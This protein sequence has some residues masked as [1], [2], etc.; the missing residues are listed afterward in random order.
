ME[1]ARRLE[2]LE[3]ILLDSQVEQAE[4]IVRL[5]GELQRRIVMFRPRWKGR[6]VLRSVLHRVLWEHPDASERRAAYFA[7]EELDRS[8]E[9]GLRRLIGLRNEG[10]RLLGYRTF[11]DLRVGFLGLSPAR[12]AELVD[13][14]CVPVRRRARLMRDRFAQG[15]PNAS[16]LP[17]DLQFALQDRVRLPARAFPRRGMVPRVIAAVRR[18]G[19]PPER[20]RFRVVFHDLPAGGLTLAP[21]PPRDVRVVVH[22]AGGW[23]SHM[24]LFHEVGHAVH[25]RSIRAPRHLLRWS[26]NVPGLGALHEGLAGLF[27]E[28]PSS[29]EWLSAQAGIPQALAR[30]YALASR[31][32][33]AFNAASHSVWLT[34]ELELYRHPERDPASASQRFERRLFGYDE[35]PSR[36]FVDSFYVDTPLYSPNYLLS[37]LFSA[38]LRQAL[39]DRLGGPFWP[40]TRFGPWL[41]REWFAGGSTFDWL[42]RLRET[43]GR[44]FGATAFRDQL[45]G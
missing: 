30:A 15:R 41:A 27:E 25:E 26:E 5:R 13:E 40:N 32:D 37:I 8:L 29:E 2:L 21:D 7:F 43:T 42:T 19:F 44:P 23:S 31:E 6:R 22:P 28:I 14:A 34:R 11:A 1:T 20:L 33:G 12:L 36:S 18:W 39:L 4:P 45:A 16:W 17:W 10:A 3:R 24:I 38:Q 35:Y 9:P